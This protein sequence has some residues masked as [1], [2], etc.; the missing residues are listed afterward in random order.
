MAR[1]EYYENLINKHHLKNCEWKQSAIW[2]WRSQVNDTK[3]NIVS[4]RMI[5]N[6]TVEII[7]RNPKAGFIKGTIRNFNFRM[8]RDKVDCF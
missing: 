4:T 8:G 1:F 3:G 6:D 7:K 2:A 5:D